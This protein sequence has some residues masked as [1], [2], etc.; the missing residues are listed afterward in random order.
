MQEC[1]AACPFKEVRKGVMQLRQ[2]VERIYE[3]ISWL[4]RDDYIAGQ[5][6][7]RP[8]WHYNAPSYK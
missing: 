2:P 8:R 1:T 4:F 3:L 6:L 7:L 5:I